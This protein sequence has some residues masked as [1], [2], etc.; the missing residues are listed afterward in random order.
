MLS[1]FPLCWSCHP[2]APLQS[3]IA[4]MSL[5][6]SFYS[7]TNGFLSGCMSTTAPLV[8]FPLPADRKNAPVR[9]KDALMQLSFDKGGKDALLS[10]S[11]FL[12]DAV[13]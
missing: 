3:S 13:C 7:A 4:I 6:C 10:L 2:L 12:Q 1:E 5:L 9:L 11:I 8:S